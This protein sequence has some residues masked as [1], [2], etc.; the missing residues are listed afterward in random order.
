MLCWLGCNELMSVLG[1]TFPLT[2]SLKKKRTT[3]KNNPKTLTYWENRTCKCFCVSG[4]IQIS[5]VFQSLKSWSSCESLSPWFCGNLGHFFCQ[6]FTWNCFSAYK[7]RVFYRCKM[8]RGSKRVPVDWVNPMYGDNN[9]AWVKASRREFLHR[10]NNSKTKPQTVE[11][12]D[13]EGRTWKV[14]LAR[15]AGAGFKTTVY[16]YI[17]DHRPPGSSAPSRVSN[18][19]ASLVWYLYVSASLLCVHVCI[20]W[21]LRPL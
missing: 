15:G 5:F 14:L 12:W 16:K 2:A 18:T 20:L 7:K 3:K 6:H 4:L 19:A 10:E 9:H 1:W 11:S 17:L 8:N 21:R 13:S